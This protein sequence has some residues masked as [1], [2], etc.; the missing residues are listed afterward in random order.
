MQL[1]QQR[2]CADM[3]NESAGLFR[4]A[5]HAHV[6]GLGSMF[7]TAM[8][9][10]VV[11]SPRSIDVAS[12]CSAVRLRGHGAL[13]T[14]H[15]IP[16]QIVRMHVGALTCCPVPMLRILRAGAGAEQAEGRHWS[17]LSACAGFG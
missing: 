8:S 5:A 14:Y 6:S 17:V 2:W 10:D 13:M 16:F 3:S 4:D 11:H 7:L 12:P 9:A 1:L 15:C